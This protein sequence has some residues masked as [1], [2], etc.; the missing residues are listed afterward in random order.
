M[1]FRDFIVFISSN[2]TETR[3]AHQTE[4]L[5][6]RYYKASKENV[7]KAV[8]KVIKD[9]GF[10][11]KRYELDRG[12]IVGN[13]KKG[14]KQLIVATVITVKPF[15]TAVDFSVSTDSIL[16]SDFGK[17]RKVLLSFYQQLD[18]ELSFIGTGLGDQLL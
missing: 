10:G 15:K 5:K 9:Q 7:M 14:K 13:E 4:E 18:K 16:P 12:E 17:S 3:E 6:T 1:G 2:R 8:E 11:I